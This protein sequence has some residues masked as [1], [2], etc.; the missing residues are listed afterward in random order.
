M[1]PFLT[2]TNGVDDDTECLLT[3]LI[4]QRRNYNA[5]MLISHISNH[6]P[7][8]L[9]PIPLPKL[10]LP[11]FKT[12]KQS[13]KDVYASLSI[14]DAE[15]KK[16]T[17]F[18]IAEFESLF[19]LVE[20]RLTEARNIYGDTSDNANSQKRRKACKLSPRNRLLLGLM[21]VCKNA[22]I[23][24]LSVKFGVSPT[25]VWREIQWVGSVLHVE[26]PIFGLTEA[27]TTQVREVYAQVFPELQADGYVDVTQVRRSGRD[28]QFYNGRKKG[29]VV[30]SQACMAEN[31]LISNI[32]PMVSGRN[33]DKPYFEL[34]NLYQNAR[35]DGHRFLTDRGY[36][37]VRNNIAIMPYARKERIKSMSL[38][39]RDMVLKR[40]RV[41]I[42]HAFGK[43]KNSFQCIRDRFRF[44]TICLPMFTNVAM[45]LYNWRRRR[46]LNRVT[47]STIQ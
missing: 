26:L 13:G 5:S 21:F 25:T 22:S 47:E 42:E 23:P 29:F 35:R 38:L 6:L 11:Q 19:R 3:L 1:N 37:G 10:Q 8:P 9:Q 40:R 41:C 39:T 44:S 45:K 20:Y 7:P 4:I 34:S 12:P 36:K 31:G 2:L 28:N 18:T 33:H 27:E 43:I 30:S 17:N 24:A 32:A 14:S 46:V 16:D 15:M